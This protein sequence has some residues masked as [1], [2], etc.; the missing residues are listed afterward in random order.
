MVRDL[1]FAWEETPQQTARRAGAEGPR[2]PCTRALIDW[3]QPAGE[4]ARLHRQPARSSAS[5]RSAT[6]TRCRTCSATACSRG[7]LAERP[8]PASYLL[9]HNIDTLGADLDPALLGL[10]IAS[11]RAR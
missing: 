11:R 2:E 4:G 8:Q 3:A 6:G 5:T 10:H 1:R 7:L 9:V